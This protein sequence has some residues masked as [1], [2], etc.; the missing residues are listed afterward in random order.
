MMNHLR[1]TIKN[2]KQMFLKFNK[3]NQIRSDFKDI[4]MLPKGI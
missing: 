4:I 2:L 1:K 3:K